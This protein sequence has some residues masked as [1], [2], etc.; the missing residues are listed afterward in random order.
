M[1][2]LYVTICRIASFKSTAVYPPFSRTFASSGIF[3]EKPINK[4]ANVENI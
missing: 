1:W 3:N 4:Y 2:L